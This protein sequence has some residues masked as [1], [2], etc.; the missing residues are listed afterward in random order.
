MTGEFAA[1][2]APALVNTRAAQGGR[3]VPYIAGW[4]AI[5]Q[6]NRIFGFDGW[7]YSVDRLE[8][9]GGGYLALVTVQALGQSRQDVGYAALVPAR[10]TGEITADEQDKA[11]KSAVTD[12]MK[13][14]L[15][16]FGA[17]FGNQLYN[18]QGP[19][20]DSVAQ[21]TEA[22]PATEW[23]GPRCP[24]NGEPLDKVDK[25]GKSYHFHTHV[26]GEQDSY[27][28]GAS[29]RVGEEWVKVEPEPYSEPPPP[30][31]DRGT[32]SGH[33]TPFTHTSTAT[34]QH[35]HQVGPDANPSFCLGTVIVDRQGVT[36]G[37]PPGMEPEK[38]D[39][40][41]SSPDGDEVDPFDALGPSESSVLHGVCTECP[42]P[43]GTGIAWLRKADQW[44]TRYHPI[45][46][47]EHVH[48]EDRAAVDNGLP[49]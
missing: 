44:R 6:A 49:F 12:A 38:N 9:I 29:M 45:P 25:R 11:L 14:G 3:Q 5:E 18:K 37:Y 20:A 35:F 32:C 13:R 7:S 24:G 36:V 42:G 16:S 48:Q 34:G 8:A 27:C 43:L 4:V 33:H 21:P 47:G 15:R 10:E 30:D 41:A 23:A 2:L 17:Q 1:P 28:N 31:R 22:P 19:A 39:P 26:T 40:L 46:G